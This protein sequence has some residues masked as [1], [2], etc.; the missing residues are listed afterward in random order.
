MTEQLKER[1]ALGMV[2]LSSFVIISVFGAPG[3]GSRPIIP[4]L[5][6]IFGWKFGLLFTVAQIVYC[7]YFGIKKGFFI[8]LGAYLIMFP[9]IHITAEVRWSPLA[10]SGHDRAVTGSSCVSAL[11]LGIAVLKGKL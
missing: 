10:L 4:L 6:P 8:I 2:V 9:I 1:L 5:V 3:T 11:I 7:Q